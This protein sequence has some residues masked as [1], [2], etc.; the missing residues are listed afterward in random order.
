MNERAELGAVDPAGDDVD[1]PVLLPGLVERDDVRVIEGGHRPRLAAQ[2]LTDDGVLGDIRLNELE[3]D[4]P[5]EPE[6][7]GAVEDPETTGADDALDLVAGECRSWGKH[8]SPCR[9]V[10]LTTG[11]YRSCS[12]MRPAEN[13]R[14]T[15]RTRVSWVEGLVMPSL[16]QR[17]RR[18][19]R[20][21]PTDSTRSSAI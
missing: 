19:V 9:S 14:S 6:L 5:V 15:T 12:E 10:S 8:R 16:A 18:W 1:G 4:R 20:T 2:P 11:H 13:A 3:R 17:M 21:S 7:T